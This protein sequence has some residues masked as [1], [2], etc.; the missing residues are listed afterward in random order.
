MRH[1]E[2]PLRREGEHA[3]GETKGQGRGDEESRSE[4]SLLGDA[5]GDEFEGGEEVGRRGRGVGCEGGEGGRGGEVGGIGGGGRGGGGGGEGGRHGWR[6]RD[7]DGEGELEVLAEGGEEGW[8]G[9]GRGVS[10]RS[11][12]M[13]GWTVHW[14]RE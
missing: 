4:L 5:V 3:E 13:D 6:G 14:E 2:D 11:W 12:G 7:V 1:A 9:G 8:V 10:V